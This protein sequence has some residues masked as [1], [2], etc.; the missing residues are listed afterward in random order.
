VAFSLR[1]LF[2]RLRRSAKQTPGKG[3][4]ISR[5]NFKSRTLPSIES[6]EERLTP[7]TAI[8]FA[9]NVLTINIGAANETT[10]LSVTG[11]NLS[12]TSNDPG[13]TTADAAAQGLGFAAATGQ[14]A[15]NTGSIA[16][17]FD[18]RQVTIT[19]TNGTQ[20]VDFQGGTFPAVTVNNGLIGNVFFDTQ[21]SIF[22]IISPNATSADLIVSTPSLTVSQTVTTQNNGN[23][24]LTV[25]GAT[26]T[27]GAAVTAGGSGAV[28][29][30]ATGATSNI[31]FNAGVSSGTGAITATA[32]NNITLNAGGF[33]TAANITLT[34]AAGAISEAGAGTISGALLTTSSV[35]GTSLNNTNA[36]SSFSATDSSSNGISLTDG[37]ITASPLTVTGINESGGG[38]VTVNNNNGDLIAIGTIT[39][40][41]NVNLTASGAISETGAGTISGALLTTSSGTGTTLTNTNTV[42]SFNATNATSGDISF[43][44][45]ANPLTITGVSEAG[46]GNLTVNNSGAITSTGAISTTG[47][48]SLTAAGTISEAGAGTIGSALLT[49]NSSGGATLNNAN[50]V[51]SF[52]ATNS[53]GGDISL[54]NTVSPLA[55]TGISQTGGGNVTVNN[56][57]DLITTGAITTT[58]NVSLASG[59]GAITEAG[60]GTINGAL[61]TTTSG[62]GTVLNNANT[63]TSFNATNTTSG[64]IS[65]MNTANPLTIT[66]IS[67]TGGGNV[68]VNNGGTVMVAGAISAGGSGM[69]TLSATGATSDVLVNANVNS[70]SGALN[71]TAGQNITLNAGNLLTSGNISLTAG[72]TINE[73]GAG[74]I[75]GALLATVSATGTTLNNSNAVSSFNGSNSGNGDVTLKDA[76]A[77]L[78]ITG[79]HTLGV[80]AIT[81]GNTGALT[82]NGTVSSTNG[83]VSLT[84]GAG[85]ALTI[86]QAVT[87]GGA[88]VLTLNSGGPVTQGATGSIAAQQVLLLG[89]GPYTLPNPSNFASVLAANV[90]N[91][92]SFAESPG[93]A[94]TTI[95]TIGATSGITT[96][97]APITVDVLNGS[98]TVNASVAAGTAAV[99]LT[100]G[101]A[102]SALTSNA[103]ITGSSATL[104]ADRMILNGGTIAV[105][106][107][108]GNIITLV[109][110]SNGRLINVGSTTDVAANTLELSNAELASFTAGIVRIGDPANGDILVSAAIT[111]P[112]GWNTLSLITGGGII[113][114]GGS[115]TTTNLALQA[116]NGIGAT[117]ALVTAV[118]NLAFNN[119]AG[120]VQIGNT[121]G[122]TVTVV[123]GLAVSS[124]TGTTTTLAASSPVTF[125]VNTTSIGTLTATANETAPAAPNVDNVTVNAGVTVQSTN[126]DVVFQAGDNIDVSATASVLALNGNISLTSG[127]ADN[128]GEGAQTLDGT[129]QANNATG[130]VTI[131]VSGTQGATQAAGG[132]ISGSQLLLLGTGAAGSFTLDASG[133]NSVVTIAA[134]TAAFV[135]FEDSAAITLG[136]V[137]ATTG[138]ITGGNDVT[139]CALSLTLN[140]PI[141]AGIGTVRLHAPGGSVS[142]NAAGVITAANL[143]VVANGNILLDVA[144]N[145]VNGIFAAND[146]AAGSVIQFEDVSSYT[147]GTVA[148]LGCFPGASGLTAT[149]STIILCVSSLT[150]TAPVNA[151]NGDIL[152][153][154]SG[155]VTQTAAGVITA[156][157]LGVNA[158]GAI[159]LDVAANQVSGNF[160]AANTAG[161]SVIQFNDGIGFSVGSLAA[162]GCFTGATGV[163]STNGNITLNG[164]NLALNAAVNAG[165]GDVRLASGGTV[166]QT[167]AGVITGANLGIVAIGGVRLDVANNQV[168]GNL[169]VNNTGAGAVVQFLDG[170]GFTINT[171]GALGLF[172]GATG[173]TS[174]NGNITLC[175]AAITI[176]Q[177][178]NAGT[179]DVRLTSMAGISQNAA[180]AITAANLGLLAAGPVILD[181]ATNQVTDNLAANATAAGNPIQFLDGA[182]VTVGSEGALSCFAGAAG[183]TTSNGAIV[184]NAPN[185]T[186]NAAL[187]AGTATVGLTSAGTVSQNAAGV[188]TAGNLGLN[189][190]GNVTLDAAVN[191]VRGTFAASNTAA[192]AVI[193]FQDGAGFTVGAFGAIAL[194]GGAT[195]VVS[196][197]SNITLCGS[198]L[199]ID[200]AINAGTA[201]VRLTS[202]G[203][204]TQNAAGVITGANLGLIAAGNVTLDRAT[205]QITGNLAA[206]D[207]GAGSVLQFLD[208]AGLTIGSEAA[209]SCFAGATGLTTSNG[210]IILNAPT[211]DVNA[212][213][214]AGTAIVALTSAGA[215]SQTAAGVITASNLGVIAAGN[216]I[217]DTATSQVSGTFAAHN[218]AAGAV[219]QFDSGAGFTV[220]TVPAIGLFAGFTGVISNNGDI[221]L[222]GPTLS[223][224]TPVDAGTGTVRLTAETG[225]MT[226]TAAGVITAAN[227]GL[228]ANDNILLDTANNDVNGTFAANT[229]AAG[230]VILFE[231][232]ATY[233]IGTITPAGCFTGATGIT[234]PSGTIVLCVPSLDLTGPLNAGTGDVLIQ[235]DG[236]VTQTA[237]GVITAANLGV[238]AVGN[239]LLDVANNQ[240]SG[241][242][243]AGDTGAGSPVQFNDGLGFTVGSLAALGCFL[244]ATGVTSANGN[245]TLSGPNLALNAAVNAGTGAVRLASGGTVSQTAAGLITAAD[246]GVTANGAI[247][248]DGAVNR[249][250]GTVA[251]NDAAAGAVVQFQ[252]GLGFTINSVAA[253]GQFGGATG[254]ASANGDITLCG[255]GITI[256]QLTSAGTADVRLN[257]TAGISQNAAGVITGSNLGVHAAGAVLL[258]RATNQVTGNLAANDSA[259]GSPIQFLDG[260]GLTIGSETALSCF[261]GATGV[262]TSSGNIVLN[263]PNLTLNAA[264]DAGAATVGLTSG[265]A[266]SQTATGVITAG[267][268]GVNAASNVAL[269]TDVNQVSGTLATHNTTAGAVIQFRDGAGLTVGTVPALGLF[270]ATTGVTSTNGDITL[271]G[272][273]LTLNAPVNSGTADVRLTSMGAITQSAAGTITAANLG[274]LAAGNVLLTTTVNQ[275]AGNFAAHDSAAGAVIEFQDGVGFTVGA[276]TPLSC[277]ASATGVTTTNGNVTLCGQFLTLANAVNAG[278][279]T[280]RLDSDGAVTENNGVSITAANLGVTAA[281]DIR[282]DATGSANAVGGTFAASDTGAGNVIQFQDTAGFTVGTIAAS[283]CFAGVVGVTS[284]NGNITLCGPG[285]HLI[286]PVNA[287]AATVR[288]EATA[289]DVNQGAATAGITAGALG[290]N[291]AG[292]IGLSGAVSQVSGHFAAVAS[293]VVQFLNGQAIL[294]D[295]NPVTAL[296]CFMTPVTG[297]TAGGAVALTAADTPAPGNDI[298]ITAGATVRSTG[299]TISL[300]AGDNINLQPGSTV[301]ARGTILIQGDFGNVDAVPGTTVNLDGTLQ[302]DLSNILVTGGINSNF[303]IDNNAGPQNNGGQVSNILSPIVVSGGGQNSNLILDDTGASNT[304]AT[305]TSTTLGATPGDNLFAHPAGLTYGGLTSIT[306]NSGS[307]TNQLNVTSL[308]APVTA[309]FNASGGSTNNFYAG[310]VLAAIQG[311]VNFNGGPGGDNRLRVDDSAD[312][313]PR[314]GS[315]AGALTPTYIGGMGLGA[316]IN[317]SSMAFVNILQGQGSDSFVIFDTGANLN[318][319]HNQGA[320]NFIRVLHTSQHTDLFGGGGGNDTFSFANGATLN[321]GVL[322]GQGMNNLVDFLDCTTPLNINLSAG[323]A[324]SSAGPI[325]S[326][327]A[328]IQDVIGGQGRDVIK[329]SSGTG[330]MNILIG[331]GGGDTVIG[332]TDPAIL[333]GGGLADLIAGI[334]NNQNYLPPPGQDPT[335]I[336]G[337]GAPKI[338]VIDDCLQFFLGRIILDPSPGTRIVILDQAVDP[339]A[340]VF[341]H[342]TFADLLAP[343]FALRGHRDL[344]TGGVIAAN[345]SAQNRL[346]VA[347]AFISSTEYRADLINSYYEKFLGRAADPAGLQAW[348]NVLAAGAGDE[349]VAAGILGSGEYF[350]RQGSNPASF[351]RG[352]YHD[353]LSRAPSQAEVNVWLTILGQASRT[354]VAQAFL[355][356]SEYRTDLI[357]SWYLKYLGRGADPTGLQDDLT[358]LQKGLTQEQVQV[359]G[360][361]TST[362]YQARANTRFNLPADIS[363]IQGLYADLLSRAA[364]QGEVSLW[365]TIL[366]SPA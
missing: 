331:G 22:A 306:L 144:N 102:D 18:V 358:L 118:S 193:Q 80:G 131:N 281:G 230:S 292:N 211:L 309:T 31:V 90:T 179:A 234:S 17:A 67:Q 36:V 224:T 85:G 227:L 265:G 172:P 134:S 79:V 196:T 62:T 6:L 72:A 122:L 183:V 60:A 340:P 182:G 215:V 240:V 54:T 128:D 365:V 191:Q 361:L 94:G 239:I 42:G 305:L 348:L 140:A 74:T 355:T 247:T 244:G 263:A 213:V 52:N 235:S 126:G 278:S 228:L 349:A 209:L 178:T 35:T 180:G 294:V 300:Q 326:S 246:L 112:A 260:A 285:I 7:T 70:G 157:N 129:I 236:P 212:A 302:S 171:V 93:A 143:G 289:G 352:L 138:I 159:Q 219:I 5:P 272:P 220:G 353:L 296:S 51:T 261:P 341:S 351:I 121:G 163:V 181:G 115:L 356:S 154:A 332:G 283:T 266:V 13:G 98:L 360:I 241:S 137:G 21:P 104:T 41:G 50:T 160:A 330:L 86:N 344:Q 328:G 49:T 149:N 297:V 210:N 315:Q 91:A 250:S 343:L 282:L 29:L 275:V 30:D 273:N 97:N 325:V 199:I 187:N 28:M 336:A 109:P 65:L 231:D 208:G 291:A 279:G 169:A 322:L 44:D 151:G 359:V 84:T 271:C 23:I 298:T 170:L 46:G 71:L 68:T 254:I 200:D 165:T 153:E 162:R 10:I 63:V 114:A 237:A 2:R 124:N 203:L 61:F 245:I 320:N 88:S 269:D 316:G 243:A 307:G 342:P 77:A 69:V 127:F 43:I 32:G 270:A 329:G 295:A 366:E 311:L 184:L 87:A 156:A 111:A 152:I 161:G 347:M 9:G 177:A 222:C 312:T 188:I 204:I 34:A 56:T 100:A 185:L 47:S 3:A 45:T 259:A 308:N 147:I 27:I 96:V 216:V 190:A 317:Y 321:Q 53:A 82:V 354:A 363:F 120:A 59:G 148:A 277:F 20:T 150:I 327:I 135:R 106:S 357:Q 267:N 133:T 186:L 48:V 257:S 107:G 173:V 64:D 16:A 37:P 81:V 110:F 95:A 288:L 25:A 318:E 249:V 40:T 146:T 301:H 33:S 145:N 205:N 166:S 262:T 284:A 19:G 198:T 258:D 333:F 38:N 350:A 313:T 142:Q 242:F 299:S 24:S 324:S 256:D 195:G 175:G 337:P 15:A 225:G 339:N 58:G 189:A 11:T 139:L 119:T 217:L 174:S 255:D 238:N 141:N 268:L 264:V 26:E 253:L 89:T 338:L 76:V 167:A 108:A 323:T 362:E 223:L 218:T 125:A 123:D 304:V 276:E 132:T 197:N 364:S 116:T 8:T 103:V 136:T 274:L 113:E 280:V 101:G 78:T 226:Q 206:N 334:Q 192:G 214:N 233:T 335:L 345:N 314:F 164:A 66:G 83:N 73:A 92:I 252:D 202:L 158:A 75:S 303:I 319:V 232:I 287:G 293:G 55:V 57:G 248:L 4:A 310:N 201:D 229:T 346:R 130:I 221:T 168:S 1:S 251:A 99:T 12:V 105:G 176:D 117:A 14:N 290:V 286:A 39:T 155:S 194:F 207:T